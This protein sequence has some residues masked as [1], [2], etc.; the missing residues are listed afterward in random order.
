MK[1]TLCLVALVFG[2][3]GAMAQEA[4]SDPAQALDQLEKKWDDL[5]AFRATYSG[6][7]PT[8][9]PDGRLLMVE[10]SGTLAMLKH[11]GTMKYRLNQKVSVLNPDGTPQSTSRTITLYDGKR[12]YVSNDIAGSKSV[13]ILSPESEAVRIPLDAR[14]LVASLGEAGNVS[15]APEEEINGVST[16][17][18]EGGPTA[19]PTAE[20]TEA[21]KMRV[22]VDKDTGVPIQWVLLNA[23][24]ETVAEGRYTDIE[25]NPDLEPE[26][27]EFEVPVG[28]TV[29][30]MT[31]P[32]G[33]P[34]SP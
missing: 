32:E 6:K 30:D 7:V 29:I 15:L 33:A 31:A 17:V 25:L 28:A 8:V 16:Y 20:I 13:V 26:Q 12:T 1:Y 27:F 19:G 34:E 14:A 2:Y 21:A 11:D 9:Q 22:Y 18:F 10:S 3:L 23:A 4:P 24:G 5:K